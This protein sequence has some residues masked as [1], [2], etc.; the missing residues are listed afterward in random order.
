MSPTRL[1]YLVSKLL[2]IGAVC[3]AYC[4]PTG[5]MDRVL[6][7]VTMLIGTMWCLNGN[8]VARLQELSMTSEHE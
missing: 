7:I 4:V 6:C 2:L 3:C 1:G 5:S 8:E